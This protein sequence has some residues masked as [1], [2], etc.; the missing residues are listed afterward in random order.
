MI[1]IRP[2]T[3]GCDL[4]GEHPA[5]RFVLFSSKTST[6]TST[7]WVELCDDH[8]IELRN[9]ITSARLPWPKRTG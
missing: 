5:R 8:A 4:C 7:S 1:R 9:A 6:E 3:E 2:T